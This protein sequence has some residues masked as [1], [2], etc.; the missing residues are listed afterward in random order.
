MVD[1]PKIVPETFPKLQ[2][3]NKAFSLERAGTTFIGTDA[4]PRHS[5]QLSVP[6]ASAA[7]MSA[8]CILRRNAT[9]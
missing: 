2:Q 8:F 9:A 6:Q 5:Q 7:G 1:F 3:C 4:H